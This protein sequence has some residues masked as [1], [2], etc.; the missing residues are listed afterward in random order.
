VDG[1]RQTDLIAD[2]VAEALVKQRGRFFTRWE[3]V[4]ALAVSLI[5]A[6]SSIIG[7]IYAIRGA[8]H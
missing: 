7:A 8:G 3:R 5:I 1:L 6:G 2:Q 4:T